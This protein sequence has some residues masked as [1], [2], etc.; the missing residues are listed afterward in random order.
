MRKQYI[1]NLLIVSFF[2]NIKFCCVSTKK[3][4]SVGKKCEGS[5]F[6]LLLNGAGFYFR[7]ASLAM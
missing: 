4:R 7:H 5:N 6:T 1:N 2:N 3:L